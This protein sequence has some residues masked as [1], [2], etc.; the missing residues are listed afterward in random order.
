MA[1]KG[2]MAWAVLG[3]LGLVFVE[4]LSCNPLLKCLGL[5]WPCMHLIKK[6]PQS[7]LHDRGLKLKL[8]SGFFAAAPWAGVHIRSLDT[9]RPEPV[10]RSLSLLA[11]LCI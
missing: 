10:A 4:Q 9:L 2:L 6:R 11:T 3:V 1:H 5:L 7:G 8:L